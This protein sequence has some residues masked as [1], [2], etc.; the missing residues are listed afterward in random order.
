M[1]GVKVHMFVVRSHASAVQA[2][3]SSQSSDEVQQPERATWVH[4]IVVTSHESKVQSFP[5]S[6]SSA[7][8][9]Q[10]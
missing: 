9:V 5:S 7:G 3:P 10:A 4:I 8:E 1:M 2:R 6:Q